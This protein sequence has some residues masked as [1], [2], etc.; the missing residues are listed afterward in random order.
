MQKILF[1]LVCLISFLMNGQKQTQSIGFIENKGQIIDQKGRKNLKVKYLLNSNGL[2]V[3]LRQNGF[4]YDIYE[5]KKHPLTKRQKERL[6]PSN[7]IKEDT[8]KNPNYTLEYIY[9]RIDIDFKN[10][11]TSVQLIADEKS[12]D[13]DNYYNIPNEPNGILDVH[14]FQK[15]T[16]E[17]IYENIDVVFFIPEDKTKP[18]EYNFIVKPNGNI[19]D[20]QLEFKGAKTE[21]VDNKIKMNVRFGQMEETLPLSW[22]EN[23]IDKNEITVG[24]KKI[25]NNIYGFESNNDLTG[26]RVIIDPTPV[27][28]WG[29]YYGGESSDEYPSVIFEKNNFIYYGGHT[30][31]KLNIAT[32]GAHQIN[33]SYV[34]IATNPGYNDA[35]LVKFD[36]NG[37][38]M[39]ST[40][41]GGHYFEYIN[42]IQV[43]D[44]GN[45]YIVGDTRSS[46]NI[47]TPNSH[48]PNYSS[49]NNYLDVMIVKFNSLGVRDWGTYFGSEGWDHST[50]LLL[51]SNENLYISGST[52]S[53][54]SIATIGAFKT[55]LEGSEAFIT[56]FNSN[57]VQIWGTYFGGEL[58]DN[59]NDSQMDSNGNI[60]I[61]GITSSLTNI[62]TPGASQENK[63]NETDGFIA[64][65]D[66]NG[67]R[68]W[69]TYWGS[70]KSDIIENL[71]IDSFNNLYCT[72]YSSSKTNIATLGSYQY[73]F[74]NNF[75]S[76]YNGFLIKLDENGSKQWGTY[77]SPFIDEAAVSNSGNIYLTGTFYY[78]YPSAISNFTTANAYKENL[79]G[80]DAYLTKFNT[81]GQ[82]IWSTFYGGYSHDEGWVTQVGDND[83]VYIAGQTSSAIGISTPSSFQDHLFNSPIYPNLKDTF[84]IKFKDCQSNS[85]TSSN[86]PTCIG[87][88]LNLT[89]SGGTNYSWTGPNG[90]TSNLQN[91]TIPN[92]NASHSGQYSCLI[93]GTG[94]C[95]G[96]NT[97]NV[98]VGDSTKPIPNINPLPSI[99][100]DCNT[101][102]TSPIATDNCAGNLTATTT[103]PLAYTLP[104]NYTINWNYDDGNGNIETQTQTVSITSVALPTVSSPQNFCIQQNATLN[105]IAITGQNIKWYDAPTS[106]N[107]ITST[108]SLID[109]AIYYAS[110]TING[111]ESLRSPVTINIQNTFVPTGNATQSFCSTQNATLADI[112]IS[113]TSIKWYNSATSTTLL[114]ITT[115]LVD[116]STYYATQTVN[117]C[118]SVGRLAVTI[119]L[120]NTLNATDYSE[121]L[122]DDLNDGFET[123][124][125]INYQSN[126]ITNTSGC[127]FEYYNSQ[128][129]ANNQI[130]TDKITTLSNYNLTVGP[131]TLFVRITSIN[132]CHQTVK[133]NLE[134]VSNPVITIPDIIPLCDK[135]NITVNAGAGFTSYQWSTGATTQSVLISQAGSYTVTVNQNHGSVVCSSTKNFQVVLSNIATILNIETIDMSD[136]NNIIVINLN[137]NSL[138]NY[139]YSIDGIHYQDS[140]TFTNLSGGNYIV[141]VRDKNGC[142]IV[143]NNVFL[144]TYPKFFS[145]NNDGY[146]DTWKINF[147]EVEN[148]LTVNIFDR[149][150]K[151]LKTLDNKTSW[152][153]TYNGNLMFADDYWFVVHRANGREHRG[154]FTLKR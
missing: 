128:N 95:D 82:R 2:N 58:G 43:S 86:S 42:K 114:P 99:N 139:E 36:S 130:V 33:I 17:N 57:G 106:G 60:I 138:G 39:W 154:H 91:P 137:S 121:I 9:H 75:N 122:C 55:I 37:S 66:Q 92:A 103:D 30:F 94:G 135:S 22:T 149:Y 143:N 105:S 89:A 151:L 24:Y 51:D 21:L 129:G 44:T 147:S 1:S 148:G 29:T 152:D 81:N 90:F 8:L 140:N 131:H 144:L 68:I 6:Y 25:K 97:I 132:T 31:S 150:G 70:E 67:N 83:V 120:I 153:G 110:Q 123:I 64:K 41:Y 109:G 32:A 14:K 126:L 12:S 74:N 133:L 28:L 23:G 34:S 35:F 59:A 49:G 45:V 48:Q 100:G 125:L 108:T 50:G 15:V 11:N 61:A 4:S 115:I 117:G 142:G 118:E 112:V 84:L 5:I 111:C 63:N 20:I 116:G 18:V 13:Y 78:N 88:N 38:R 134:L 46:N 93:T 145:P 107:L 113:G 71:G 98:V 65:F 19:D 47:S 53:I 80:T 85:T 76:N 62:S 7:F 26:K 102:I 79:E 16:Y 77:F 40:Y 136:N 56:K 27:R 73:L 54:N 119:S 69:G 72:G 146:N 104:G 101:T 10:S 141:Y 3:Q 87:D 96:T 124:N 52:T 127:T